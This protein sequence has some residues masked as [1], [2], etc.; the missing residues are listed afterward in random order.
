MKPAHSALDP[1]GDRPV[2]ALDAVASRYLSPAARIERITTQIRALRAERT[3]LRRKINLS[4]QEWADLTLDAACEVYYTSRD[5]VLNY[6]R[7]LR[8]IHARH[9]WVG[10]LARVTG[11][12]SRSL[13]RLTRRD[14]MAVTN[15]VAQCSALRETD[16]EFRRRWHAAAEI[17]GVVP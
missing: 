9:T 1:F 5:E 10:L 6:D 11:C 8:Q 15:S 14:R 3:A 4:P 2:I 7:H 16:P 13:A 17:A 12:G